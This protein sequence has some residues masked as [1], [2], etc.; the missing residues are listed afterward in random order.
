MPAIKFFIFFEWDFLSFSEWNANQQSARNSVGFRYFN[1][2]LEVL[3]LVY[4]EEGEGK[5]SS[6]NGNIERQTRGDCYLC[7]ICCTEFQ[8]WR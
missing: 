6:M 3:V 8:S 5:T 7:Y 1:I 4:D 2:S